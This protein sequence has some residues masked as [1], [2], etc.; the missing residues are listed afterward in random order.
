MTMGTRIC[1]INQGRVVQIGSPM[2]VY[3]QPANTFVAGFLGS[4]PMNLLRAR[5]EGSILKIGRQ[6]IP[7]AEARYPVLGGNPREVV[8][9]IRPED[10]FL[11]GTA[12]AHVSPVSVQSEVLGVE[13]LGAETIL[14]LKIEEVVEKVTARVGRE[15]GAC[16]GERVEIKLD[17]GSAL[18]F[19]PETTQVMRKE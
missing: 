4:P 14:I 10:I 8:F 16:R 7:L 17:M 12:P 9:G 5:V 6:T 19:N 15:A 18:L 3:R 13:T 2:E 11:P 1:I